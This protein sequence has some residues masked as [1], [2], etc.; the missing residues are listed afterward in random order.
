M[1]ITRFFYAFGI[2][3]T[4]VAISIFSV[5]G[6]N[7]GIILLFIGN[8]GA[9]AIAWATVISSAVQYLL[10]LIF[11]KKMLNMKTNAA[12]WLLKD[13]ILYILMASA[14]F[15]GVRMAEGLNAIVTLLIGLFA[16]SAVYV[17]GVK[18]LKIPLKKLLLK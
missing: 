17:I 9:D 1:Y 3:T 7:V 15:A 16:M 10:L 14:L 11:A 13:G 18:S 5:F 4:P 8:Y 6:V 12:G 2:S